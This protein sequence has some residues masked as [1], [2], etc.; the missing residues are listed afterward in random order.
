MGH[1]ELAESTDK[2]MEKK[3]RRRKKRREENED[4]PMFS[5]LC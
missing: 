3:R 4:L 5:D 2:M 1:E